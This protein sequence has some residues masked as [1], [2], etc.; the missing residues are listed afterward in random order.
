MRFTHSDLLLIFAAFIAGV[1]IVWSVIMM[2]PTN[3]P[4]IESRIHYIDGSEM[5]KAT[6]IALEAKK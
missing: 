3:Q 2:C 1:T 4:S 5:Q 6:R